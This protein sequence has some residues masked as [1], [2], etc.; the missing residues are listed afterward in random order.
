MFFKLIYESIVQA[1]QQLSANKLRSF[2]SLTG[3]SIGIICIISVLSAVDSLKDNVSASFEKLG[4]DVLYIDKMPWN[5][6][7]S[8]NWWKYQQRP[9]PSYEDLEVI[10]KKSKL[11]DMAS[12]SV[13]MPSR[14]IKFGASSIEGAFMAGVTDDYAEIF[15]FDFEKG[16]FFTPFESANGTNRVILG[17]VVAEKLFGTIDPIGKEINIKGLDFQ[18]IGVLRKEGTTLINIFQFDEA[19]VIS[20]N[21]AKKLINVKSRNSWGTSLNVKAN[22]G[23]NLDDLKDEITGILRSARKIKPRENENFAVN[24]LSMFTNLLEPIFSTMNV[25]GIFIGGFS[26]LVGMFS[27]ANIMFVSVK[28]RTSIIGIKKAL[29][30]RP[31]VILLEFLIESVVLCLVGALIGLLIVYGLLKLAT[32]AFSYEIYLSGSNILIALILS[33]VIGILSGLIPA[34]QAARLDP[35]EAMRK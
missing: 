4:N 7:P 14:T 21:T 13:F 6:D 24:Q 34:W 11:S 23:V 15:N 26:I 31:I 30:A 3:I 16:R 10:K 5:E 28:E 22:A 32:I 1:F 12:F 20:F 19:V 35:V 18:V 9:Q 2:L 29:G 33:L 8:Q 17:A 27:V 25:V